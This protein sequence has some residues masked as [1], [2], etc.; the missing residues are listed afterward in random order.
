MCTG[1]LNLRE[2]PKDW[3]YFEHTKTCY[4]LDITTGKTWGNSRTFCKDSAA[5]G[6]LVSIHDET[7]NEFIL[8]FPQKAGKGIIWIGGMRTNMS[9]AIQVM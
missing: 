2:C 3:I 9:T 4:L 6:D 8:S 7:T 5:G 1:L